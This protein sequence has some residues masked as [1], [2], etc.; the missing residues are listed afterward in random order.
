[1]PERFAVITGGGTGGHVVPAIA[2][3]RALVARGH[4]PATVIFV[5]SQRGI[6]TRLVPEAGFTL[7]MLPGR[8]IQRRLTLENL[9]AAAGMTRAVAQATALLRRERPRVVVSVGGYASLPCALAAVALRIPL[10]L[11]EQNAAPGAANRTVARFARAC[12]VS[13]PGTPLP[14][15]RVTGNPVR[16]DVLAVDRATGADDARVA[17]GLPA[18]R[19]V[20]GIFGGS[21]G[22]LRINRAVLGALPAWA[23]R[24]DLAIHHVVG[25]RDW[26][27]VAAETPALAAGAGLHYQ[28]V[29]YED[30][31]PLLYTA[32]DLFVC[33][34][35]GNTVAE[36][37]AVGGPAILVPLPGAPADHQT[38]NA[39]VFAGAGAAVLV[40]DGELDG[41]KLVAEV[42]ALL[43][44]DGRLRTMAARAA[45][46]G[47]RDAADRVAAL[48]EEFAR[49]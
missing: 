40:A 49:D 10:I 14:R 36:L 8:G 24:S 19:R 41:A 28:A 27:L 4:E 17:L 26:D 6:E 43:G 30:R 39:R 25:A 2:I 7:T 31:L 15:A 32:A 35:G 5:G 48:A 44:D 38:A 33:R 16:E 42:D 22:A 21:L 3:G 34:A 20:I 29:R 13:Y 18:G 1:M 12:A 45:S 47:R 11:Q 37:A 23:S 46:L 9:P